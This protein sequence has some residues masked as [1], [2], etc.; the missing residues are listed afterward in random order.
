[1]WIKDLW[2]LHF[3]VHLSGYDGPSARCG[4]AR[5][6]TCGAQCLHLKKHKC[7]KKFT[8]QS[9]NIE[10]QKEDEREDVLDS[11]DTKLLLIPNFSAE[12]SKCV[13]DIVFLI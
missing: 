12:S 4:R 5:T 8:P 11:L 13:Q 1:M 7:R 2:C 6:E 3:I 10:E 9:T